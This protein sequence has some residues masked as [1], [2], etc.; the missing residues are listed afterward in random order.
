MTSACFQYRLVPVQRF[1]TEISQGSGNMWIDSRAA[2]QY[3]RASHS[4]QEVTSSP[5]KRLAAAAWK[6]MQFD[7]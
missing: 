2:I 6:E 4:I 5:G 3:Q 7:E 1:S